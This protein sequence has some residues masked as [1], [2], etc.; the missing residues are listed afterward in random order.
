MAAARNLMRSPAA[1][2]V[3]SWLAANYIRLVW[4]TGRWRVENTETVK[5]MVDAGQ[6]FIACFW[7]GR[8]LMLPCAWRHKPRL[9]VLISQHR[10]GLLISR[11]IRNL[12]LGTIAGSSSRGG[13]G[14]LAAMVRTLKRGEYVG[15][16]PDGPRGPRMH[17]APGAVAA[18]RLSGA[19]LLPMSYSAS[20]CRILSSWDRFMVPLPFTRGIIRMGEP[21]AV[22]RDADAD[23][24]EQ[25]RRRLEQDL[26]ALTA[27]LDTELGVEKVEPAPVPAAGGPHPAGSPE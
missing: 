9:S 3:L 6:P 21:I 20:R 27:A 12:G 24:V 19:L 11:A 8:M 23:T 4:I 18:A 1:G 16:T 17:A 5:R 14:A 2:A 10:D 26:V 22:P 25:V 15:I 7:H 13:A